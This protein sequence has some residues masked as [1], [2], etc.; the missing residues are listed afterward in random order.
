MPILRLNYGTCEDLFDLNYAILPWCFEIKINISDEWWLKHEHSWAFW[1]LVSL[2]SAELRTAKLKMHHFLVTYGHWGPL[3]QVGYIIDKR[4]AAPPAHSRWAWSNW[5]WGQ[6]VLALAALCSDW[7]RWPRVTRLS[8]GTLPCSPKSVRLRSQQNRNPQENDAF[9]FVPSA[10]VHHSH[11]PTVKR[12]R[13][14]RP[15]SL[16]N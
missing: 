7:V 8:V 11:S 13:I 10:I 3:R 12:E 14:Q 16:K 15:E 6:V 9:C 2:R 5:Y 4:R 1:R